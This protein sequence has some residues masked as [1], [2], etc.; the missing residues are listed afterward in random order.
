MIEPH[1]LLFYNLLTFFCLKIFSKLK[2]PSIGGRK[3]S[4]NT[5]KVRRFCK[6]LPQI[7][8]SN[9]HWLSEETTVDLPAG[10]TGSSEDTS[11]INCHD[12]IG[13]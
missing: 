4:K 1:D 13:F 3:R 2:Q 5:Q 6:T 7:Y 12:E 11:C 10:C 8:K 9:K